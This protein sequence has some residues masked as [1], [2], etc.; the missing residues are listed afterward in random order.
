MDVVYKMTNQTRVI[1][2][3]PPYYYIGSKTN[4]VFE[5]GFIPKSLNF[6]LNGQ[7]AIWAATILD[8]SQPIVLVTE[9]GKEKEIRG[10]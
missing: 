2:Q 4:C 8:I 10:I 6:G 5:N 3:T 7:Y 1:N 9:I